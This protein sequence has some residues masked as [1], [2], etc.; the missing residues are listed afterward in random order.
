MAVST[1]GLASG[2][3][4][5]NPSGP[6]IRLLACGKCK[7]IE[8]LD[9]YR[10]PQRLAEEYD[11]VLNIAVEKHQDGVE[12]IPH[13]P[14]ALVRVKKSDWDNEAVQEQVRKQIMASFGDGETGLGSEAY[15]I[16]DNFQADALDCFAKHLRN[17]ECPDYRSDSKRLVPG[18]DAERREVGMARASEYDRNNPALT[19]Y[20]CDYCPVQSMVLQAR[21]KKAG[22]YDK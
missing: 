14:A 11:V 12:R 19:K 21:R 10:G 13:A 22:M 6:E 20:L 15:A 3:P 2:S 17:P 7:T 4:T 1:P 16:R 9:D 8:V 18:T 5:N